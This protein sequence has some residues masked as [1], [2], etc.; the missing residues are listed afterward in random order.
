MS[1]KDCINEGVDAGEISRERADEALKLFDDLEVQYNRQM[2]RAAARAKAAGDTTIAT[3]KIILER[4]RRAMLQATNWQNIIL[5]LENYRTPLG[6]ANKAEGAKAFLEQDVSAKFN[7]VAQ[8]Q[9]AVTRLA[10]SKMTDYLATFKRNIV[11]ETRN[12]AKLENVVR[13]IFEPGVTG[14]ASARELAEAWRATSEYL[15]KR[16]NAA[17][18]AIPKR[19]DWGMPQSHSPVKI[20]EAGY[21]A[22]K[23]AISGKLDLDK[24]VDERTGLK[25][26]EEKLEFALL[27]A[28][29][30]ITTEGFSNIKVG[31]PSSGKSLANRNQDHRFFVFKDAD[32]WLDYQKQF[33]NP[34]AFDTMMGHIDVM[35]RDIGMLEVLG[36]NPNLTIKFLKDTIK[37]DAGSDPKLQNRA[38]K[39]SYVIDNVYSAITGTKN[40]PI[41]ST[42]ATTFAGIRQSLTSIHLGAAFITASTDVNFG[43]IGRRMVGLPQTKLLKRYLELMNPL[44]LKEKGKL[45]VRI[46]LTAEGWS[47]LAAAQMRYVGDMSGPEFTRR[48]AD[49]VMRVSLLS[50]WT[51]AGKWGFGMDFLGFLA[52]NS[53]SVYG[54]L[55]ANMQKTLRHYNIGPEKWDVMR[56]TPMYEH[57]G[58]SFLRA[59]DIEARTDI[60]PALAKELATNLMVMIDTETNFAVPSTSIRGRAALTGDTRPGTLAGELTNSFAMYKNFGTTLI[61]THGMRGMMESGSLGKGQYYAGLIITTT[62][63][64]ALALQMSEIAKGKDPRSMEDSR[65]WGAALMKGGGLGIF[66]DFLFSDVNRFGGGLSSTIAGP[67][68]GLI[69]DVS[70]LTIGNLM[71]VMSGKDANMASDTIKF[72]GRNTPGSSIWYLRLAFER[73]VIDQMKLFA[74]PDAAKKMRQSERRQLNETGQDN[75]W[76]K[77]SIAPE[78]G[79]DL[80]AAFPSLQ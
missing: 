21:D 6:N 45:A 80:S 4:K 39:A 29:N 26:S 18:G 54:D 67:V 75:W 50:P 35:A 44:T 63:M 57:K 64:G 1:F 9:N 30:K 73:M 3:K 22:W 55:P 11:G 20:R 16:F 53:N 65:F 62:M 37:K 10:T 69:E 15:R 19:V 51:Q 42:I 8:V 77:G 25:F 31:S 49:G 76:G 32:A 5:N 27:D 33:G 23:E 2:G 40:A 59:E 47:Q 58:A 78:R 46:G 14:D 41:D 61:S 43:R 68:A 7:S 60:S 38:N 71:D 48:L 56:Q 66:G 34:N 79:P 74:D 70:K 28:Y 13:E 24:M 36:P 12:K 17:G 72:A 52:D